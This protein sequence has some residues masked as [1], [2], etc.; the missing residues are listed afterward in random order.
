MHYFVSL[1][2]SSW[3]ITNVL[4]LRHHQH[5]L[6]YAG[7]R[8]QPG[9]EGFDHCRAIGLVRN[10]GLGVDRA[11]LDLADDPG[12]LGRQRIAAGENGHLAAVE[13]WIVEADIALRQA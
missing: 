1:R 2:A 9:R 6:D 4:G 5:G 7:L 12:E 3:I 8:S 10:P 11:G 13:E